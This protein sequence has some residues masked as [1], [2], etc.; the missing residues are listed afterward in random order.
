[1]SELAARTV[2]ADASARELASA[3]DVAPAS[4]TA[5][6]PKPQSA[7]VV[8]VDL[9]RLVA[10]FQMIQGHAIGGLTAPLALAG[11]L[12]LPWSFARGL[13]S[14]AFLFTA[15]L[16]FQLTT[17]GD[18]PAHLARPDAVRKRFRRVL[19]LLAIGY[20]L[21]L[22]IGTP[23]AQFLI[24]DVLQCI[25]VT[26]A[27]AELL[28]IVLRRASLVVAAST[29]LALLCVLAAPLCAGID[30]TGPLGF[31]L[32]Y[33]TRTGGSL[34]PLTPYS[35][36][37][38]FGIVAGAIALPHGARTAPRTTFSRLALLAALL[39]AAHTL[40]LRLET[41][42]DPQLD[43][44]YALLKLAV[45]VGVCAL[46][47]LL[48]ARVRRLPR[49]LETLSGETLGLYVSHLLMLYPSGIGLVH[50]VGPVLPL[51]AAMAVAAALMATSSALV[52]GWRARKQRRPAH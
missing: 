13:T 30:A 51:P 35:A 24:V 40:A 28:C 20:A 9:L 41:P 42:R 47:V 15:G 23:L 1:M 39:Y 34:F 44:S 27:L 4:G 19:V 52:L 5:R 8:A 14:V 29:A 33:V 43:A 46:L 10:S 36:D 45:V 6:S 37:L 31:L 32:N 21:H 25:G 50:L 18:L 3:R 12:F 17:L 2:D 26:L 48:T 16:A 38:F 11:P 7:R 22:P 49:A